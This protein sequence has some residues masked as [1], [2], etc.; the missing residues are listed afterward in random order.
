ML[1]QL[2]LIPEAEQNEEA[3][4]GARFLGRCQ[5][6]RR[7]VSR[8]LPGE[9]REHVTRDYYGHVRRRR[10][11]VPDTLPVDR[12]AP[13]RAGRLGGVFT[14]CPDCGASTLLEPVEGKHRADVPCDARCTGARGPRCECSCGG[15]NHGRDWQ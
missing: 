12:S 11:F 10:Y 8:L 15:A 4:H 5:G 1:E 13:A 6:C 9:W 3:G 7:P 2:T 14:D